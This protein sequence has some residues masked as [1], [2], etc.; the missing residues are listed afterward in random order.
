[1]V[2]GQENPGSRNPNIANGRSTHEL[3]AVE[4][5]LLHR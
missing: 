5:F 3:Q 4:A 1:V 2:C